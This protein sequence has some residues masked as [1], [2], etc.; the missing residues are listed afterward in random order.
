[1]VPL[2]YC[3]WVAVHVLF[4]LTYL[5]GSFRACWLKSHPA[6]V[7]F[8][9]S[10][11]QRP[12]QT[13]EE[14]LQLAALHHWLWDSAVLRQE[15]T[16]LQLLSVT[17]ILWEAIFTLA[18]ARKMKMKN[19]KGNMEICTPS[20]WFFKVHFEKCTCF[21]IHCSRKTVFTNP[22]S[23]FLDRH[24]ITQSV[25]FM[26]ALPFL[27][28]LG[29]KDCFLLSLV[30]FGVANNC[31]K[32]LVTLSNC[33][34]CK[35]SWVPLGRLCFP[36][37]PATKWSNYTHIERHD[38]KNHMCI[39]SHSSHFSFFACYTIS[40]EILG[41]SL[42]LQRWINSRRKNPGSMLDPTR[43][44]N[45]SVQIHFWAKK[46]TPTADTLKCWNDRG[47]LFLQSGVF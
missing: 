40:T 34:R 33:G 10:V 45:Y 9:W 32:M 17:S 24:N 35:K 39:R 41:R 46:D 42:E 18:H 21:E 8:S 38:K 12:R 37:F 44:S 26:L 43:Q 23:I 19:P 3:Q 11:W 5:P 25:H 1:M 22:S 7:P 29:L 14:R 30:I 2:Q 15:G 27:G 36:A 31:W 28:K 20:S 16:Q 13:R 6:H 4:Q 47:C